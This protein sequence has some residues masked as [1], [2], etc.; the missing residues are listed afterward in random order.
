MLYYEKS[1]SIVFLGKISDNVYPLYD[2]SK[3][4]LS[5]FYFEG[6]AN[7]VYVLARNNLCISTEIIFSS[8]SIKNDSPTLKKLI[9]VCY[10]VIS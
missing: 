5:M 3:L 6:L 2:A 4:S 9:I 7:F 1:W 10:V 8:P